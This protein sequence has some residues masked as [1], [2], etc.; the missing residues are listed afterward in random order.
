[1]AILS[2]ADLRTEARSLLFAAGFRGFV[3]IASPGGELLVTDVLRYAEKRHGGNRHTPIGVYSE[4]LTGTDVF[5]SACREWGLPA[6]MLK[7]AGFYARKE[8]GLLY[9]SPDNTRL[10]KLAGEWEDGAADFDLEGWD[11]LTPVRALA[12]RLLRC[13]ALKEWTPAGRQLLLETLRL[14]DPSCTGWPAADS[15]RAGIAEMLRLH[16]RSGMHEAGA[17]LAARLEKAAGRA[18]VLTERNT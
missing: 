8:N 2:A 18:T 9:I 1:M 4:S 5:G 3:R 15:L 7:E 14:S 10:H 13:S 11:N 16:D 6:R 17:L 12:A